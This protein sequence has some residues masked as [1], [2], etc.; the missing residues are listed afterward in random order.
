[1]QAES[2][3]L[4]LRQATVLVQMPADE[5]LRMSLALLRQRTSRYAW[6]GTF[7]ACCGVV[8]A[9]LLVAQHFH[10]GISYSTLL[11]AQQNNVAIWILDGMPFL[12]AIWG[13]IVSRRTTQVAGRTIRKRTSLLRNHLR[14]EQLNIQARTDYFARMSHEFRT[15]LHAILGLAESMQLKY[16]ESAADLK[17]IRGAAE[18]LLGLINDVLDISALEAGQ[19]EIDRVEFDLRE[20]L[21]NVIRLLKHQADC[22]GLRLQLE[23]DDSVPSL[24]VGDPGRLRQI[25]VNV[26]GNA[27]KFTDEGHIACHVMHESAQGP[28][29]HRLLLSIEDTG[30]GI[31]ARTRRHLFDPY[32]RARRQ[33]GGQNVEGSG[34]GLAITSE[35]VEAM[36]GAIDVHSEPGE[37]SCFRLT[38]PFEAHTGISLARLTRNIELRGIRMLLVG[39]RTSERDQFENQLKALGMDVTVVDDGVDALKAA[40][41]AYQQGS[42]FEM[43]VTDLATEHLSGEELARGLKA[44]VETSD[45]CLVA[46]TG[47]GARGDGKRVRAAGFSGYLVT[48]VPPEHL[49]ELLKATLATLAIPA[50]QRE[51]KGLITRHYLRETQ[52]SDLAVLAIDDDQ[53]TLDMLQRRFEGLGC[54]FTAVTNTRDALRAVSDSQ[55]DLVLAD[56][57][58]ADTRGDQVI[59][60]L[61]AIET[62]FEL[63]PVVV[64]SAGLTHAEKQRCLKAGAAG[65][66]LKPATRDGVL[67]LLQ[68][69]CGLADLAENLDQNMDGADAGPAQDPAFKKVFLRESLARMADLERATGT[70]LDRELV[71]RT[72][73]TM[74]SVARHLGSTT[75]IE[76]FDDLESMAQDSEEKQLRAKARRVMSRWREVLD[77]F[78]DTDT[79]QTVRLDRTSATAGNMRH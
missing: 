73:H 75:L 64:H 47:N 37:G 8:L 72:A 10:D 60:E 5:A 9:S 2:G 69:F 20:C 76:A 39:N 27:I 26:I 54:H 78:D 22:K 15:P 16:G 11:K 77:L 51:S 79:E 17:V 25:L 18:G 58:L 55:Y 43:L 21:Q 41:R 38:L 59:L 70:D 71:H 49:A 12:F 34:L 56:Y 6:I 42:S 61:R 31:D 40:L 46:T 48:P 74:R 52:A 68:R 36:G 67:S 4:S 24:V 53:V 44:R 29:P 23:I 30:R 7:I 19:V 14:R 35:L 33:E 28:K 66:L 62:D 13:Q 45:I 3:T 1:M 57:N 50:E 32:R 63:P 65:F